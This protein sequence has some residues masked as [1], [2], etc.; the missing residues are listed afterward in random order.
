MIWRPPLYAQATIVIIYSIII[1]MIIEVI[2]SVINVDIS[3]N[4]LLLI[5]AVSLIL[6][7]VVSRVI[8]TSVGDEDIKI[9][10]INGIIPRYLSIRKVKTVR[11]AMKFKNVLGVAQ[12]P[13]IEINI[14]ASSK[15]I[16]MGW[17]SAN[18]VNEIVGRINKATL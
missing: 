9:I 10:Y 4:I 12:V 13:F 3:K 17:Y 18:Q 5:L 16:A 11:A 14:G 1:M 6:S 2:L 8:F 15:D 7:F